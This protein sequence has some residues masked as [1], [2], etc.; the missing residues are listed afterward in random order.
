M[1]ASRTPFRIM[2]FSSSSIQLWTSSRGDGPAGGTLEER[3]LAELAQLSGAALQRQQGIL[4]SLK[5]STATPDTLLE[6]QKDVATFQ[7]EMSVAASLA[8]KAVGAIETLVKA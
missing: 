4:G 2:T 5:A 7:L 8:R 6:V 3:A 1:H